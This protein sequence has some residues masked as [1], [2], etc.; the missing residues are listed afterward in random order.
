MSSGVVDGFEG[1]IST[2]KDTGAYEYTKKVANTNHFIATRWLFMAED[3]YQ[4]IPEKWRNILDECCVEAGKWEQE[5]AENDEASM[6]EFLKDK[7]V[8]WNDV[9]IDAFTEACAPVYATLSLL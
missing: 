6:I 2:L 7:G 8:E 9:D 1:S 4:S 3:V 5:N